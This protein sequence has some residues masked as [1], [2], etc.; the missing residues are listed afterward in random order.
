[1]SKIESGKFEISASVFSL[2]SMLQEIRSIITQRCNDNNLNFRHNIAELDELHLLGDA[3][4]L[5]QVLINL[6]GNAVKFTRETGSIE[7]LI[8]PHHETDEEIELDFL[9][10]DNGIGM[11]EE[12]LRRLFTAFDQT[13]AS[14]AQKFGGTGLGLAIS[15]N[16]I[17][18]MGNEITVESTPNK[19]SSFRFTLRFRKATDKDEQRVEKPASPEIDLS[20]RRVLVVDDVPVNRLIITE[21]LTPTNLEFVEVENGQ[22]AVDA[23]AASDTGFFDL[24]LMDVQMPVMDGYKATD[25]IRR[26]DREDARAVPIIAMTANAYKEDVD[27]ALAAGMNG[28]VAKPIDIEVVTDVLTEFLS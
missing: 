21:L 13:D 8:R 7:F 14:V 11:T 23:F 20:G 18:M 27:K 10:T 24:I 1:M 2:N 5:K 16:L 19:G 9:V 26:L 3:L 25:S 12:Q 6:L 28:H 17:K 15:Q 4:R 22:E